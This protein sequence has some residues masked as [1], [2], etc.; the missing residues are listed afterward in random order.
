M[1]DVL[2]RIL[3][4]LYEQSDKPEDPLA[5]ISKSLVSKKL[6]IEQLKAERDRLLGENKG[7]RAEV[8][9]LRRKLEE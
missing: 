2:T 8:E 5:F 7:L 9:S 6:D 1:I 3:I 4:E